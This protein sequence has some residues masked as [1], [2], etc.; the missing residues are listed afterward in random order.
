MSSD[1]GKIYYCVTTKLD[2]L[3]HTPK[4][5]E[6]DIEYLSY[7]SG[8]KNFFQLLTVLLSKKTIL[9]NGFRFVDRYIARTGLYLGCTVVIL[10]HGRNE[11]FESKGLLLM[12]KKFFTVPRYR[13]ESLFLVMAYIWFNFIKLKRRPLKVKSSCKLLYF[14]ENYKHLWIGSLKEL[15]TNIIE[16]KVNTP[17]PITW[18]TEIPIARIPKLPVFLIDE[19]LDVTIGLSDE[20]FFILLNNLSI[21]LKID[22]IYTRRHPRS[23]VDK[24]NK[25]LNI[26]ETKDVPINVKIL[27][28]YKSNLLFCGIKAD[29][30]YQFNQDSLNKVSIS[31]LEGRENRNL[32]DYNGMSKEDLV[33]V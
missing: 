15:N 13:Y 20:K 16:K 7:G 29:K 31:I 19:P 8:I 25:S 28:G 33:C 3:R 1:K 17:N 30:F 6:Q 26:I 23:K 24:F 27:I 18:G 32:N 14:T 12:I 10:Q 9:L 11:Y 4:A 22:T 2:G 5:L 21:R